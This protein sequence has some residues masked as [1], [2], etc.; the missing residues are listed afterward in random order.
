[1][2][3]VECLWCAGAMTVEVADG[4][5]FHCPD[6]SIQVEFAPD[7]VEASVAIAA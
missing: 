7:P 5:E 1:M 2:L 4:D 3:H 6:C